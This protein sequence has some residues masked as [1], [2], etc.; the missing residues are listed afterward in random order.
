[1]LEE[2]IDVRIR[3]KEAHLPLIDRPLMWHDEFTDKLWKDKPA[4]HDKVHISSVE[5]S[6]LAYLNRGVESDPLSLENS[7][8]VWNENHPESKIRAGELGEAIVWVIRCHDLGNIMGSIEVTDFGELRPKFFDRY[9]AKNAE[10][11]SQRIA[12]VLLENSDHDEEKKAHFIPFVRHMIGESKYMMTDEQ[13]PF[14]LFMRVVDQIGNDLFSNNEQRV[15]GL[16]EEML[17]ENPNATFVPYNFMNFT[18]IRFPQLLPDEDLRQQ[19]LKVW[20]K[21]LPPEQPNH[22]IEEILIADYLEKHDENE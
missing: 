18:R 17:G 15:F 1:M 3:E 13:S 14:A 12:Q 22:S 6:A 16:L 9:R 5:Q 7:V 8:K 19:L 20:G 2:Q 21:P 11:R 4:F 10:P